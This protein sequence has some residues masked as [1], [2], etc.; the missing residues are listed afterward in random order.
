MSHTASKGMY[1]AIFL[2]LTVL[3]ADHRRDGLHRPGSDEIL[4]VAMLVA[5]IR[6]NAGSSSSSLYWYWSS[7]ITDVTLISAFVFFAILIDVHAERLLHPRHG[8][9]SP[10]A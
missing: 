7:R 3:T 8:S 10:A 1:Y 9:A 6:G 2:A 4:V 5:V